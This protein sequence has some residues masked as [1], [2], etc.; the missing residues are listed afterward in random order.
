MEFLSF[1]FFIFFTI[2]L[3]VS[4][5]LSPFFRSLSLLIASY[6]FYLSFSYKYLLLLITLTILD[7]I[8]ALWIDSINRNFKKKLIFLLIIFINAGILITFKY[9]D[10]FTEFINTIFGSFNISNKFSPARILLP[11]GISYYIFKKLSYLTD[12]Y[13]GQLKAEKDFVHFAL[14]I[15]FFPELIA[16]PIDRASNLLEQFKNDLKFNLNQITEGL[17][18]VGWG[19]FKKLVIADRVG[20]M[21]DSVF[22]SP[23]A[24]SRT[25][26]MIAVLFYSFQIYCDFSGYTDIVIGL[27]RILGFKLMAN[28]KQPY[29]A[30]SISDFW[31]RWHISLS[32]WL[33]DYLFLPLSY[34]FMKQFDRSKFLFKKVEVWGYIS[35]TLITMILCGLWHG[36]KWTFVFWGFL[37]GILLVF[38]LLTRKIRKNFVKKIKL[39]QSPKIHFLIKRIFTFFSISFL[40]IFFR[41]ESFEKAFSIIGRFFSGQNLASGKSVQ[42]INS[43]GGISYGNFYISIIAILILLFVEYFLEKKDSFLLVNNIKIWLRWSIY[44]F[45]IFSILIFGIYQKTEFIY[46]QF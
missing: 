16:G 21:V 46:G 14:Y 4:S 24:F 29:F 31:K 41:A 1:E 39:K 34:S 37:H 32:L 10:F 6:Y 17:Q 26:V 36:A 23:D 42:S 12:V 28:F 40:W 20:I 5:M 9:L 11:I 22:V 44:F 3:I 25:T 33:R 19:L 2:I 45:F 27:S 15:S 7:Y 13:R 43:I 8:F 18:L 30:I 38:S 35:G